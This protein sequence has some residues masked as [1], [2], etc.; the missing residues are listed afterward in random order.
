M[1]TSNAFLRGKDVS[2]AFR[3][4]GAPVPVVTKTIR[5]EE[6]A[7]TG[8]DD[9]N[10]EDRERPFIVTNSFKITFDGYAPDLVLLDS[11]LADIANE[12]SRTTPLDK[13]IGVKCKLRDGT[14]VAYRMRGVTRGPFSFDSGDRKATSMQS[15]TY[16]A[17][18]FDKVVT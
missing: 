13:A 16:T 2:L 7:T 18:Y 12:D 11:C 1:A 6:N 9:C 4:N 3:Q 5:V 14:N 10:G 8:A 15:I 17:Q